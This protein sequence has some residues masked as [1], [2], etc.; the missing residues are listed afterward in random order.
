MMYERIKPG[1]QF[2]ETLDRWLKAYNGVGPKIDGIGYDDPH[3]FVYTNS[4]LDGSDLGNLEAAL[5][6]YVD[7]DDSD[8]ITPIIYNYVTDRV[9]RS[10][11]HSEIDYKVELNQSLFPLRTIVEGEVQ[12]VDWYADQQFSIP[13]IRTEIAYVRDTAGFALSRQTVRSWYNKDGSLN[14][15]TK[16]TNKLYYTDPVLMIQ[17]GIRRRRNIIDEMKLVAVNQM[18]T[19]FAAEY[20]PGVV[21]DWG[22]SFMAKHKVSTEAFVGETYKQIVT[23]FQASDPDHNLWLDS[24]FPGFGTIRDYLVSMVDI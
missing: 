6:D 3:L 8:T 1:V 11:H 20:G 13:V 9:V 10:K 22:R 2:T 17:E 19:N 23:D 14:P 15:D 18:Q 4:A 24:A 16:T 12:R 7:E 5:R 21:L